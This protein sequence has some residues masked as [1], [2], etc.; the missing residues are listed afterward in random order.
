MSSKKARQAIAAILRGW[1]MRTL[2][3]LRNE[4]P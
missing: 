1:Q 2:T 4:A 3:A